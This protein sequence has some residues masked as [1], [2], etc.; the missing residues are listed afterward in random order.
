[1]TTR[2][3][4]LLTGASGVLGSALVTE[5]APHAELTC[6]TRRRSVSAAGI[7]LVPGDLTAPAIGLAPPDLA[8][9]LARTE[10][11]V[12]CG[13]LTSFANNPELAMR[14]NREGTERV[15]DLAERC[16]ASLLHVS[17]AFV[18]RAD[19]FA[20]QRDQTERVRSP[21]AYLRS[22]VAAEDVVL[23]SGL[24]VA[25]VRPSVLLGDSASGR[26]EQFQGW[27]VMCEG[28]MTGQLPF[29]PAGGEAL[30]DCVPVDFAARAIAALAVSRASGEWWLTAGRDAF[31]LD[32]CIDICL[33]VAAERGM[34]PHRPRTLSREMVERLVLPAFGQTAPPALRRQMLE[35]MELMRLFGSE[36][37]FPRHWPT[38][39]G[40][41]GPS[42]AELARA[43]EVSLHH[44]C[45]VRD[46][47]RE[48]EVA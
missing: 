35:G 45:D 11:I 8:E 40:A 14:V 33:D 41:P 16:R 18:A 38:M 3:Q 19:E 34:T 6:L 42:A 20:P 36:H 15:V 29:F 13:A 17:T 37:V 7:R 23:G 9:V 48:E 47:G 21:E 24:P 10:V 46:L 32:G 5:L 44:I 1:M 25:V 30:V 43:F 12:H 22:K 28:I 2:P 26:I 31:T 27:H 4:I 39:L